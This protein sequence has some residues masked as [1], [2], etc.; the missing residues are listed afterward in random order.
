MLNSR[1]LGG[2]AT[3]TWN[4]LSNACHHRVYELPPT[5]SELNLALETVWDLAEAVERLLRRVHQV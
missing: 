1:E 4:S 3:L 5:S 2:R